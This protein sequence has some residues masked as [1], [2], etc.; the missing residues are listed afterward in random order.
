MVLNANL[1]NIHGSTFI[2]RFVNFYC[3]N[4]KKTCEITDNLIL[5]NSKNQTIN[6]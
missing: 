4:S 1:Q 2:K 3:I 5:K 6:K